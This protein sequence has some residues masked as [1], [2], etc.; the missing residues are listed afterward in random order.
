M[1]LYAPCQKCGK[2][3]LFIRKRTYYTPKVSTPITSQSELCSSCYKDVKRM[4]QS[5]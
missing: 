1:K 5:L 4:I 3:R 2:K